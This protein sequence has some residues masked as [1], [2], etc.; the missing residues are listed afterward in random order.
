VTATAVIPKEL[1]AMAPSRILLSRR[2]KNKE[3][4]NPAQLCLFVSEI[5][6]NPD[7]FPLIMPQGLL[8]R[9]KALFIL[10]NDLPAS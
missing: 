9:S 2:I 6:S 1:V 10:S 8:P 7:T 3:D 5:Q 4:K